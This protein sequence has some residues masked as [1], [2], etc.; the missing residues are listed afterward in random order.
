MRIKHL[1]MIAGVLLLVACSETKYV[2]EGQY[3]LNRVKVTSDTQ[4]RDINTTEMK[5]LVKQRGN[6]RWFSAV[7]IPLGTYSLSGRD[8]TRWLN[9]TLRRR[10]RRDTARFI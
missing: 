1:I 8:T 9:R 10:A 2:P 7:K 4:T 6:T 3:L 5:Q